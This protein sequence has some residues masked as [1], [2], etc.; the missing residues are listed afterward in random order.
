MNILREKEELH[1]VL[2][3]LIFDPQL[4]NSDPLKYN[5]L[6]SNH[7]NFLTENKFSNDLQELL[8]VVHNNL[9][10]WLYGFRY[11]SLKDIINSSSGKGIVICTPN[12]YVHFV[13]S[14]IDT[15]RYVLNIT[16]PI[17]IF[18]NGES[19]LTKENRELLKQYTNVYISDIS[20]YFDNK[21]VDISHWAIK[22]FAILASRFEEVILMD[23]DAFYINNPLK[24]FD[25]YKYKK[26]GSLFFKD[27]TLKYR[28]HR[29][30]RPKWLK[31]FIINPLPETKKSRIWNKKSTDELESSTV[32][33]HKTK[34]LLGLLNI[35][36]LNEKILRDKIIYKKV[37]GDKET[38]WL[39][40]EMSRQSYNVIPNNWN[41]AHTLR[42]NELLFW[43]GHI[44]NDKKE[45]INKLGIFEAYFIENNK[46][47]WS[48]MGNHRCL[49]LNDNQ[50]PN[51]FN[52][53]EK[54]IIYE[55]LKREERN[56]FITNN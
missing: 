6:L 34:A 24:L 31:S 20:Q 51:N 17:E 4:K 22:P 30:S 54:K 18:Y 16:T 41:I 12:R 40:F 9:Y 25:D 8:S 43:N 53:Y 47:F 37:H 29:K 36:K 14:N 55:I 52:E 5:D 26:L 15:F 44:V 7:S 45:N 38:F 13:R 3:E 19:D 39:G 28:K 46:T 50:E 27:R 35:C 56:K 49:I 10:K 21:I 33:I 2:W 1:T 48:N 11:T 42:N 32:V 23:A